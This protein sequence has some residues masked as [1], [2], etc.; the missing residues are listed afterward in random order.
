MIALGNNEPEPTKVF[1]QPKL[2]QPVPTTHHQ[3]LGS[4]RGSY[5]SLDNTNEGFSTTSKLQAAGSKSYSNLTNRGGL[6]V[7][8]SDVLPSA[9]DALTRAVGKSMPD[10][11]KHLIFHISSNEQLQLQ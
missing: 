8:G 6:M 7:N 5:N 1:G 9:V 11:K 2:S 3:T 10:H 4:W